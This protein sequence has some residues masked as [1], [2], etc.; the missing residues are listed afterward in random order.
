MATKNCSSLLLKDNNKSIVVRADG[1]Y[2]NLNLNQ[3]HHFSSNAISKHSKIVVTEN[4]KISHSDL[5]DSQTIKNSWQ[6]SKKELSQNFPKDSSKKGDILKKGKNSSAN[7]SS[8]LS[9]HIAAYEN[10]AEASSNFIDE[11]KESLKQNSDGLIREN[12]QPVFIG[13]TSVIQKTFEF[14]RQQ[15]TEEATTPE[16][17]QY[18]ASQRLLHSNQH[19]ETTVTHIDE[20]YKTMSTTTDTNQ[21]NFSLAWMQTTPLRIDKGSF[22]RGSDSDDL[23]KMEMIAP[24]FAKHRYGREDILAMMQK[25]T[26]PP[27]GLRKCQFFVEESQL[28]IIFSILNETEM[29]LQQNINSSKAL[30]LLTHQERQAINGA[31]NNSQPSSPWATANSNKTAKPGSRWS[32]LTSNDSP[33]GGSGYVIA[34]MPRGGGTAGGRG[35]EIVGINARGR[36]DSSRGGFTSGARSRLHSTSDAGGFLSSVFCEDVRTPSPQHYNVIITDVNDKILTSIGI[37]NQQPN[38]QRI[39]FPPQVFPIRG[40]LFGTRLMVPIACSLAQAG[41]PVYRVWFLTDTG[42][43][44]TF[45]SEET[46]NVL[47]GGDNMP[48]FVY[49]YM[50]KEHIKVACWLSNKEKFDGVNLLGMDAMQELQTSN[51]SI[52]WGGDKTVVLS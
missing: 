25:S 28:P 30:S 50:Q 18:R 16:V 22:H 37:N 6:K 39:D 15:E 21:V 34:G 49:C 48:A 38:L 7:N 19:S 13:S 11:A 42:S 41:K 47:L 43:P 52:E 20:S 14:P 45:L 23:S 32:A 10:S 9:L 51:I 4:K 35:G 46:I 3:N 26:R 17:A 27:D 36:F 33:S 24:V 31:G 29:R 2:S 40:C 1:K 5:D 8:T 44:T 12:V